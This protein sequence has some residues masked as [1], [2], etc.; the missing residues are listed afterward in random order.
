ML[1][2]Q[3]AAH[4]PLGRGEH[5]I[6][7]GARRGE[8]VSA[9]R[10]AHI[11]NRVRMHTRAG[12]HFRSHK[13][14]C[15][16][17]CVRSRTCTQAHKTTVQRTPTGLCAISRAPARAPALEL[18]HARNAAT[19]KCACTRMR[20]RNRTRMRARTHAHTRI[21]HLFTTCGHIR[22][23]HNNTNVITNERSRTHRHTHSQTRA[24]TDTRAR[25]RA[26]THTHHS[27]AGRGSEMERRL[28]TPVEAM[29]TTLLDADVLVVCTPM[30]NW[31]VPHRLKQATAHTHAYVRA[32]SRAGWM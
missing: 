6:R 23:T 28:M 15:N 2:R 10:H 19:H 32:C 17:V 13:H 11:L 22:K 21:S 24:L 26:L 1:A 4:R 5:E 16:R 25:T 31:S 12:S 30:W 27:G 20:T 3:G 7:A 18:A 9:A 29:A 8:A 14:A